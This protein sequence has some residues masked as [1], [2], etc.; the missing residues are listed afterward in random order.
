[1]NKSKQKK[2]IGEDDDGD[3]DEDY[4]E[5]EDEA[6]RQELD[7]TIET[8]LFNLIDSMYNKDDEGE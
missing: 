1:M 7:D 5:E 2:S 3:D 4:S 8:D 6:P